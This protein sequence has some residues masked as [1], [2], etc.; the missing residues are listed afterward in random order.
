MDMKNA[1]GAFLEKHGF[2][3]LSTRNRY[4]RIFH[5]THPK[6]VPSKNELKIERFRIKDSLEGKSGIYVYLD[7]NETFVYIGKAKNLYSRIYSH[8]RESFSG[9]GVWQEF[10]SMYKCELIVLWRE[11]ESDRQ[12]RAIEEMIEDVTPSIFEK[13]YPRGKRQL[14]RLQS[15]TSEKQLK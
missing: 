8:Y 3:P 5:I 15:T 6:N 9:I 12:R 10:F 4:W 11:I 1:F 14:K 2:F 7:T 13:N